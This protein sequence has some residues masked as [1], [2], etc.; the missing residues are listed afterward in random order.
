MR[1]RLSIISGLK[2][3][4]L[5]HLTGRELTF[6]RCL[7]SA[8][9]FSLFCEKRKEFNQKGKLLGK[10]G[11]TERR[12]HI[13]WRT[14]GWLDKQGQTCCLAARRSCSGGG[15]PDG[16][17]IKMK[18]SSW[19]FMPWNIPV[20]KQ[21]VIKALPARSEGL[22]TTHDTFRWCIP[23]S[24]GWSLCERSWTC[25]IIAQWRSCKKWSNCS[26]VGVFCFLDPLQIDY[27]AGFYLFFFFCCEIKSILWRWWSS[28]QTLKQ[29][30]DSCIRSGL[31]V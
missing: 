17:S 27:F 21:G 10:R 8:F 1:L 14:E 11:W 16:N 28:K 13:I 6:M 19:F 18:M 26:L 20:S 12:Q 5:C 4:R 29:H 2:Q 25:V 7:H 24:I 9:P 30:N 31:L 3:A 15:D 23:V 22:T